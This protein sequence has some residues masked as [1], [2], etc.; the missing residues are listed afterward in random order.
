M[1]TGVI[2]EGQMPLDKWKKLYVEKDGVWI[3]KGTYIKTLESENE[4]LKARNSLCP[5]CPNFLPDGPAVPVEEGA[6]KELIDTVSESNTDENNIKMV[7]IDKEFIDQARAELAS[8][9]QRKTNG[10]RIGQLENE[11]EALRKELKNKI[12]EAAFY[13]SEG[14]KMLEEIK[15]LKRDKEEKEILD[16]EIAARDKIIDERNR[17]I[18]EL[19]VLHEDALISMEYVSQT[20]ICQCASCKAKREQAPES[21]ELVEARKAWEEERNKGGAGYKYPDKIDGAAW[22]AEAV[23]AR[24][25][26]TALEAELQKQS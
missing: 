24:I 8:L 13:H 12:N 14:V 21:P 11:N 18:E 6:I 23:A 3:E 26:I 5:D 20:K 9:Q 22:K 16:N 10:I 19:E 2:Y 25:Y 4:A 17:R 7:A 1:G 15:E